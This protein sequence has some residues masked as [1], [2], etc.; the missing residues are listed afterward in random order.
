M[1][2][3]RRYMCVGAD[4]KKDGLLAGVGIELLF[5]ATH[6]CLGERTEINIKIDERITTP[7]LRGPCEIYP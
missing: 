2:V 4:Y 7:F 6:T 5:K 3:S 1:V